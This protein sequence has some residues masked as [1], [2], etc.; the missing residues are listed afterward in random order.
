[1]DELVADGAT[2][3]ASPE[4]RL[5]PIKAFFAD[6]TIA[7]FNP[8]QHR[9]PFPAA[10]SNTHK[11]WSIAGRLEEIQAREGARVPDENE[12]CR[13]RRLLDETCVGHVALSHRTDR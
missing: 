2:G 13:L 9:L 11:S 7:G 10:F 12:N 4:H 6:L 5:V 3:P 1:M 8:E